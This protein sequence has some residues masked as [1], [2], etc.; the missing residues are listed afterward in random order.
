EEVAK[1]L[2]DLE[3]LG[4]QAFVVDL[5]GNPGGL[6]QKAVQIADT[7]VPEKGVIVS[8]RSRLPVMC[9]TFEAGDG[10]KR[11]RLPMAILVN[12]GSA[13]ASEVLAGTL[14]EHKVAFLVGEK[15]YGKGS[16]QR[17]IPLA[18][19]SCALAL[20]VATYHLPSGFTPHKKGLEPDV[21]V[22]LT[23]DERLALAG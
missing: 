1:A 2:D 12:E 18:P 16:V 8:T 20:T 19:F 10:A 7:L 9:K 4:A 14:R 15:T 3:K 22:K 13:S 11:K 21:P 5:R 6:L 23:D 17:V